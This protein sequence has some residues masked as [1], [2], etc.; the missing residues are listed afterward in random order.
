MPDPAQI[1]KNLRLDRPF[2]KRLTL[3][4]SI[5]QNIST[6]TCELCASGMGEVANLEVGF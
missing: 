4:S 1:A 5:F 3:I 6:R 2:K